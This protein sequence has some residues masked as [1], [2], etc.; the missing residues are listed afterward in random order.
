MKIAI[1]LTWVKHNKSGGIESYIRNLLDGLVTIDKENIYYLLVT[2][3][4]EASF[5]KYF[6]QDNFKKE[7]IN[8]LSNKVAKRILWQNIK[9]NRFLVKKGIGICFEPIYCKP[10][11]K[12]KKIKYICTIHDL[13]AL[14]YPE[15]FSRLKYYWMKFAWKRSI[16]TSEKIIAI[17]E[18]V[19]KDILLHYNVNCEKIKVIYNPIVLNNEF[20]D[21]E[22]IRKKYNIEENNYY[23]TVS[24]LLPHKNLETLLYVL[25]KI[26]DN[27]IDLPC[28]LLISGVSEKQKDIICN[29]IKDN[30]LNDNVVFTGFVS[31]NVRNV[32]YKNCRAFL[33]PS[34][35]EG[36]GMP[37]IEAMNLGS[38]TITTKCTS[39][40]EVTE[41]KAYY[42]D[43]PKDIDNWIKVMLEVKNNEKIRIDFSNYNKSFVASKYLECFKSVV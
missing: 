4:N 8:I 29:I 39:I 23:Y 31:N 35:F 7:V 9:L 19:K 26:R 20:G 5:E 24:Q 1:D 3:D 16:V 21:F 36:F 15:Y 17:S 11:L 6:K 33:F 22:N 41:G 42:V 40:Y 34:I 27:N 37:P 30:E 38:V 10:L 28:K 25:K 14:H 32:L 2:M 12:N 43:D 18:F 13:Q